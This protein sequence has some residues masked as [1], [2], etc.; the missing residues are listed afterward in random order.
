[1]RVISKTSYLSILQV[2]LLKD[3]PVHGLKS[4]S[5]R[6]PGP[7]FDTWVFHGVLATQFLT[8]AILLKRFL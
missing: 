3:F 7:T 2:T 5:L 4:G 6:F 8:Q 1:M